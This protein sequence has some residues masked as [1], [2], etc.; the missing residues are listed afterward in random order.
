M[1]NA[2]L[3]ST[4]KD[5]PQKNELL[6]SRFGINYSHLPA[7]YRKGSIL[8]RE[9]PRSSTA[10]IPDKLPAHTE[11]PRPPEEATTGEEPLRTAGRSKHPSKAKSKPYD[12]LTGQV[13]V[14]HEDLI[15]DAFWDA[16]PWL[17]A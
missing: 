14:L 10:P 6:F 15:K 17:L 13:V 3:A 5:S 1:A 9:D 16:R 12:G 4:Y 11:S 8:V 7:Q 2:L